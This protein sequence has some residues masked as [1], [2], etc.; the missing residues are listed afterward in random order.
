MCAVPSRPGTVLSSL[1]ELCSPFSALVRL[2]GRRDARAVRVRRLGDLD[3]AG[4]DDRVLRGGGCRRQ[5]GGTREDVE[6]RQSVR[7]HCEDP[8]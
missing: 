2:V 5:I 6:R 3:D 4:R 7:T 8:P 1:H